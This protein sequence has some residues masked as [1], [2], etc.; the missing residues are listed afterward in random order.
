[1]FLLMVFL[2][3][4]RGLRVEYGRQP[5]LPQKGYGGPSSVCDKAWRSRG[6][7]RQRK[8]RA[9]VQER[10]EAKQQ[11]RPSFVSGG[12]SPPLLTV[13]YRPLP[14]IAIPNIRGT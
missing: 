9:V 13:V 14:G 3:E 5:R 2:P 7:A 8:C 10:Q 11:S 4:P 1:M 12:Q 6:A